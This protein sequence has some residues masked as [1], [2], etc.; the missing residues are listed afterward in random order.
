MI[1]KDE[2]TR[3]IADVKKNLQVQRHANASASGV[4]VFCKADVPILVPGDNRLEIAVMKWGYAVF[5]Q[6]GVVY[7]TKAETAFAANPN[8]WTDSVQYRRCI[9]PSYGFFEPHRTDTHPSPKTGRPVKDQYRFN[10]PGSDVLFMAG[11]FEER[12][13][14]IMT[15]CPNAWMEEIHPRMPMVLLPDELNVWLYGDY[16][17]LA[18]RSRIQLESRKEEAA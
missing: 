7:N 1:P 13:F 12:Q 5:W 9:V 14:S 18:D 10:L 6:K 4:D 3:I 2:L 15:T 11:V 16:Q 17:S 8:M